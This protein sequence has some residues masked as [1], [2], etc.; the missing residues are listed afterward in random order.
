MDSETA[1]TEDF[2]SKRFDLATK[3]IVGLI[4]NCKKLLK[5][6]QLDGHSGP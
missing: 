6:K 1:R 4:N 2:W 5:N 3:I